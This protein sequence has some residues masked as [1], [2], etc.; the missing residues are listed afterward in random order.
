MGQKKNG[1]GS[2]L[3]FKEK[4]VNHFYN[5]RIRIF[6]AAGSRSAFRKTAGYGSAKN[7]C[8]YTALPKPLGYRDQCYLVDPYSANSW[9]GSVFRIRIP[10]HTIKTRIKRLD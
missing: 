5:Y 9:S 4:Q 6:K 8:R 2:V 3:I 1:S 7:E 10:I